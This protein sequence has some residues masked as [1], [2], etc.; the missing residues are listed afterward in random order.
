M[1][2]SIGDRITISKQEK[3]TIIKIDGT[4]EGWMN[5]AL[6][7]WIFMWSVIGFYVAYFV[8]SGKAEEEQRFFLYTYLMFW[9]Y[10][11]IKAVYSWLFRVWGYELIRVTPSGMYIKKAVFSFGK[12]VRYVRENIKN[13]RKVETDRKSIVGAF[14]KSFWVIGNQ[15]LVFDYIGKNVGLGMH[16]TPKDRD[17]LLVFLRQQM[18]RN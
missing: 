18:K 13:L 15:Q 10:F 1:K 8:F 9:V 14:N 6:L 17:E 3:E 5:H 12:V 16:L 7:G 4:V 2:R 11:E